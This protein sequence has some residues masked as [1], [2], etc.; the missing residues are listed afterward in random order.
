[1][2]SIKNISLFNS[3]FLCG[4]KAFSIDFNVDAA[5][6]GEN[7]GQWTGVKDGSCRTDYAGTAAGYSVSS[8]DPTDVDS[9]VVFYS[10]DNCDPT[11][12]IAAS[13]VGL[14]TSGDFSS[15]KV[16]GVRDCCLN[17]AVSLRLTFGTRTNN[18]LQAFDGVQDPGVVDPTATTSGPTV[19][20]TSGLDP[21]ARRR[22]R[23]V[24]TA[25]LANPSASGNVVY[26]GAI[27]THGDQEY[28][29][30]QVA[31]GVYAGVNI[32]DWDPSV[33]TP[34]DTKIDYSSIQHRD[35]QPFSKSVS[36]RGLSPLEA[37]RF[38]WG[39]CNLNVD[40]V[41]Q[42]GT[43]VQFGI[44]SALYYAV[45]AWQQAKD[46]RQ[47]IWEF[48]NKPVIVQVTV[49]LGA[50]ALSGYVAAMTTIANTPPK[51]C[52]STLDDGMLI[53]EAVQGATAGYST[54]AGDISDL[55]VQVKLSDGRTATVVLNARV[56]G[57][58][59]PEVCGAPTKA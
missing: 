51:T 23:Q 31:D 57:E 11:T 6:A 20:P 37:R 40:C 5:C 32:E 4:I 28:K 50:A 42:V 55:S 12:E 58:T 45:L 17:S 59:T 27:R 22:A 44:Q 29:M 13:N 3:L 1:M 25:S 52:S 35:L 16:I 21:T 2:L 46:N 47:E 38:N 39:Q 34:S 53:R 19:D 54:K 48:L 9:L 7:L 15:F 14:C 33:H 10:S 8:T 18:K 41:Y 56:N 36:A 30:H 26:H 24:S 49:G 43:Y